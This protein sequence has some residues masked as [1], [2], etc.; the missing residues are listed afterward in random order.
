[1]ADEDRAALRTALWHMYQENCAHVR[2]HESQRSSV[3]TAIIA[4]EAALIGVA[5]FDRAIGPS[6]IPVSVLMIALGLFGAIFSAKQYERS[7][8]H[9]KRA[10]FYRSAVDRTFPG[11]PLI[12]CKTNADAAH[13]RV[14]P[15]LY[16]LGLNHF[17]IALYL[18]LALIGA[19]IVFVAIA[20]PIK[21]AC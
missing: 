15:R 4:I 18:S 10:G 9:M 2:H 8:L 11:A 6:D 5:T 12:T 16:A 14:F 1:M 19:A 3:T 7:K 21:A 20:F 17:W 13:K